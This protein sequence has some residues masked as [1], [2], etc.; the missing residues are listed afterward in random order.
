MRLLHEKYETS[1]SSESQN[2]RH[3]SRK[4]NWDFR[5]ANH[6]LYQKQSLSGFFSANVDK[7]VNLEEFFAGIGNTSGQLNCE[8]IEFQM[9]LIIFGHSNLLKLP[10]KYPTVPP[11][12]FGLS[13]ARDSIDPLKIWPQIR[14]P[15]CHPRNPNHSIVKVTFHQFPSKILLWK[16]PDFL[17]TT[18]RLVVLKGTCTP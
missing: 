13:S 2:K 17:A 1:I 15:S 12:N 16:P 4:K 7:T 5:W 14:P 6:H 18:N 9:N 10:P 8:F 11:P 3:S